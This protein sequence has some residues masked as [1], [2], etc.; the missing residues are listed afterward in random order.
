MTSL[1]IPLPP[2]STPVVSEGDSI[3]KGQIIAKRS[4]QTSPL[5]QS[6]DDTPHEVSISLA[7]SF[8]EKAAN[9]GKYLLKSPGESVSVGE[10]IASKKGGLT[11][12][13]IRLVS[14]VSGTVMRF[15][16]GSGNLIIRLSKRSK[17]QV[18]VSHLEPEDIY[19]PLDGK[20]T[21]C[22]NE[23]IV[24]ET[25][26]EALVGVKGSGG[27]V[28]GELDGH[29]FTDE[30]E[31]VTSSAIGRE[32]IGKILLVRKIGREAVVKADAIGVKGI[33]SLSA[34]DED[35]AYFAK[36]H[37]GFPVVEVDVEVAKKIQKTKTPKVI[38]NGSEKTIIPGH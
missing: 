25:D 24:L 26:T 27:E 29:L 30:V 31:E 20:V 28:M 11:L 17:P 12:R 33:I 14:Q 7:D 35:M 3:T 21:L 4:P 15:E 1:P 19:S 38:L 10:V 13:K 22:N 37:A 23:K 5:S 32:S 36:K 9:V 16:R 2:G 8:G 18:E 34:A 6:G